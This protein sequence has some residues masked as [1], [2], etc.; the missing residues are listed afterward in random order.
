MLLGVRKTWKSFQAGPKRTRPVKY[1]T[2]TPTFG[3]RA[4]FKPRTQPEPHPFKEKPPIAPKKPAKIKPPLRLK[5]KLAELPKPEPE[6]QKKHW[7]TVLDS[8]Q[9]R[10]ERVETAAVKKKIAQSR[11]FYPSQMSAAR[12]HL[13]FMGPGDEAIQ[14][15]LRSFAGGTPCGPNPLRAT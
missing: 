11:R 13:L 10:V 7:N 6:E 3:A 12:K 2:F 9:D 1:G 15:A 8:A 4:P 14:K 5:T